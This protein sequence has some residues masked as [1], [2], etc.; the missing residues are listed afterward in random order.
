MYAA[1]QTWNGATELSLIGKGINISKSTSCL[2][3]LLSLFTKVFESHSVH[4]SAL[5]CHIRHYINLVQAQ[6]KDI[7]EKIKYTECYHARWN[8]SATGRPTCHWI[9]HSSSITN[10]NDMGI[11][12]ARHSTQPETGWNFNIE[13][14]VRQHHQKQPFLYKV[15]FISSILQMPTRTTLFQ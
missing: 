15:C 1:S 13:V 6:Y 14:K 9:N 3:G 10:Q 12:G 11:R 7:H 2:H 4:T 8:M 5:C